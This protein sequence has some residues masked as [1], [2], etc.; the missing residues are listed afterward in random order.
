MPSSSELRVVRRTGAVEEVHDGGDRASGGGKAY[1]SDGLGPGAAGKIGRVVHRVRGGSAPGEVR[2]VHDGMTH[3]Y[4]A[5]SAEPLALGAQVLVVNDRGCRQIDVEP[6]DLPGL[7][8][9]SPADNTKG[10]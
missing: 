6:W 3:D 7:S 8:T 2:V 10:P 4:I 1:V 9:L 5:Y